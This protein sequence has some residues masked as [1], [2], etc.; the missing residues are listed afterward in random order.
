MDDFVNETSTFD[1][2]DDLDEE[3]VDLHPETGID[4]DAGLGTRPPAPG[5]RVQSL[6]QELLQAAVDS[7]YDALADQGL[8]PSLGRDITKFEL[9]DG[10]VRLKAYPDINI[11]NTRTGIPNTFDYIAGQRGGRAAIREEMGFSDWARRGAG[12]QK[13]SAAAVTALNKANQKLGEAAGSADTVELQDLGQAASEASNTLH[14][15]E[16]ALTN[17]DIDEILGTLE[18]P[19]LNLREI[20]G[21][22]KALRSIRGELTNNLAKLSELDTHI[23]REE[24]KLNEAAGYPELVAEVE[25][26]LKDLRLERAARLDALSANREALRSQ[27][28]RM[29]ETINRVLHEDTT[30]AER[31]KTLF[32]EQGITI[33]SILTAIGMTI[34]TL[35]LALTGGGSVPTPAPPPAPDKGGL[36]EWVKKHLQSLGRALAGLAG[37]AAAALPGIIG[38]VVSWLLSL[39]S[40]TAGWLAENL[41]A[42]VVAVGGLLLVAA[43][44]WLEARLPNKPKRE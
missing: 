42:V 17:E 28:S 38:S 15:L 22:D 26:R 34:S 31:I 39:L 9:V 21:L 33:A 41:W 12:K 3:E 7:Y 8:T 23:A 44:G 16:T 40:K 20:R 10:R 35:V 29:R 19:P 25:A 43:R 24:E 2:G 27:I 18:D 4:A 30:L 13:L 37:K 11:V 36:K 32:R 5:T 1:H 14:N 6:Q